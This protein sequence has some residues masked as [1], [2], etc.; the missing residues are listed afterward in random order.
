[1]I[2]G[3][4]EIDRLAA[5]LRYQLGGQ[6]HSV[7]SYSTVVLDEVF[8]EADAKFTAAAMTLFK[9]FGFQMVVATPMRSVMLDD[10][11]GRCG[12]VSVRALRHRVGIER[13]AAHQLLEFAR[14]LSGELDESASRTRRTVGATVSPATQA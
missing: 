1:M 5:A 10:L 3:M 9:T 2:G 12:R 8:D 4:E 11:H 14:R 6:D 13:R 7:P